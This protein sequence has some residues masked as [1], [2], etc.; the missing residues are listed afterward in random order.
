MIYI[1]SGYIG[2]LLAQSDLAK[3]S[4]Y[5][6]LWGRR[7]LNTKLPNLKTVFR[8]KVIFLDTVDAWQNR[9]T[10]KLWLWWSFS[11]YRIEKSLTYI[12]LVI[13][14]KHVVRLHVPAITDSAALLRL[15]VDD[16]RQPVSAPG[17][18]YASLLEFVMYVDSCEEQ[19]RSYKSVEMFKIARSRGLDIQLVN[20]DPSVN[21]SKLLSRML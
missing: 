5:D 8:K 21:A 16:A 2:D 15:V 3:C 4:N 13:L 1:G 6:V 11:P 7:A 19:R 20:A 12:M 10:G 18:T 9:A 14:C 17:F